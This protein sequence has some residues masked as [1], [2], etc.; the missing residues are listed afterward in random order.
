MN[1]LAKLL[2]R[3][4]KGITAHRRALFEA[5]ERFAASINN[6]LRSVT[7]ANWLFALELYH[8][9]QT[10]SG[11][12][13]YSPY[14]IIV[15]LAMAY[16]GA[17]GETEKQIADT[18]HLDLSQEQL[19]AAM[20]SLEARLNSLQQANIQVR[21]ANSLWPQKKYAFLESYLSLLKNQYGVQITPVDY[22]QAQAAC[23]QINQWV[24]QKTENKIK[25]LLSPAQISTL[26]R[27]ILINA[28]Y[29]KGS[30]AK[31]FSKRRTQNMPFWLT[32]EKSINV[33]MMNQQDDFGYGETA[34]L[35]ILEL[36]YA[37]HSLSM[38]I[39]LPKQIDGLPTLEHNL[40]IENLDTWFSQLRPREV[41][42]FLP[43]LKLSSGF[44]LGNILAAMGMGDA[45]DRYKANFSGMDGN[46]HWLYLSQVIHQAVVD[47]N[48]EGTEA[49]AVTRITSV[50]MSVPDDSPSLFRADHPFIFVIQDNTSGSVLFIGRIVNPG[51]MIN[52]RLPNSSI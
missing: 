27:L 44:D 12:L 36:P 50:A 17:R 14:C 43:K 51:G 52:E 29:F 13:F 3:R 40:S 6:E 46:E 19:H 21:S 4:K 7:R 32:S 16:G 18:L 20:A 34:D 37:A 22:D 35:Q 1:F 41:Y 23:Q 9:L 8:Q 49:V 11:N 10:D 25:D 26:T 31:P 28:I 30:W 33:P 5:N 2:G 24:A 39:L 38:I 47:V 48:E 45:F 15:A 42:V